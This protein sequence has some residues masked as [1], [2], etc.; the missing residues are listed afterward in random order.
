[1]SFK[2][3]IST[4]LTFGSFGTQSWQSLHNGMEYYV[5]NDV[6]MF[7]FSCNIYWRTAIMFLVR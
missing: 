7:K 3:F 5:S 2:S 1:M 6:K 4:L